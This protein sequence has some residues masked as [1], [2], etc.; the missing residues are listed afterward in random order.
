MVIVVFR[1]SISL[2][3][4]VP[5]IGFL[6]GNQRI[7]FVNFGGETAKLDLLTVHDVARIRILPLLGNGSVLVGVDKKI[8][9]TG[10]VEQR[11]EGD[12]SSDLSNNGLNF[13]VDFLDG[14][15]ADGSLLVGVAVLSYFLVFDGD[16]EL[17]AFQSL[18]RVG[19]SD[20]DDQ[21][22]HISSQEPSLDLF[23]DLIEVSQESLVSRS[24]NSQSI[25]GLTFESLGHVD[26]SL[27]EDGVDG[28]EEEIGNDGNASLEVDLSRVGHGRTC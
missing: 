11:Q 19:T 13:V 24:Q 17:P 21:T 10:L 4:E 20:D 16:V 28:R 18:S 5:L 25:L 26:S 8:E 2:N 14:L 15:V 6:V 1:C 27:V 7:D 12:A 23:D 22:L 3:L 9:G